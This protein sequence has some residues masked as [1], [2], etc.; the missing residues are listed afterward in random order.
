MHRYVENKNAVAATCQLSHTQTLSHTQPIMRHLGPTAPSQSMHLRCYITTKE[1][2]GSQSMQCLCSSSPSIPFL[3]FSRSSIHL[4]LWMQF[5]AHLCTREFRRGLE[6]LL[7]CAIVTLTLRLFALKLYVTGSRWA[8]RTS[9]S[10][11]SRSVTAL[12]VS[13]CK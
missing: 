1:I 12:S 5:L 13:S 3:G 2:C 7:T 10:A 4:V 9:V 11:T 8:G 6:R